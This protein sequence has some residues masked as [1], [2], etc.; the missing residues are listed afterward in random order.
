VTQN[1][2]CAS[3]SFL[4]FITAPVCNLAE[5]AETTM[6]VALL[7]DSSGQDLE[8]GFLWRTCT[9]RKQYCIAVAV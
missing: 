2:L 5:A 9:A 1:I 8:F 7:E 6:M 4:R 3:F